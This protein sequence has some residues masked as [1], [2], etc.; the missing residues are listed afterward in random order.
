MTNRSSL[1]TP[2]FQ[3]SIQENMLVESN[4]SFL[5]ETWLIT[6]NKSKCSIWERSFRTLFVIDWKMP[7]FPLLGPSDHLLET[8]RRRMRDTQFKFF[9]IKPFPSFQLACRSG[10]VKFGVLEDTDCFGREHAINFP[11]P[12]AIAKF[13]PIAIKHTTPKQYSGS[14][15]S[16]KNVASALGVL[17]CPLSAFLP[18]NGSW[19]LL[20]SPNFAPPA[21]SFRTSRCAAPRPVCVRENKAS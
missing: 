19:C 10:I 11:R 2:W 18:R 15:S 14:G 4:F 20:P 12:E 16:L 21:A 17:T 3:V 1:G 5:I 7:H 6:H 13:P 8:I 9:L